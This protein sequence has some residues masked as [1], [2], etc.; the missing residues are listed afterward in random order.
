MEIFCKK[1]ANSLKSPKKSPEK[2]EPDLDRTAIGRSPLSSGRAIALRW[3]IAPE[4]IA[5]IF[6]HRPPRIQ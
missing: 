5:A 2:T 6:H 4:A 1:S 3:P